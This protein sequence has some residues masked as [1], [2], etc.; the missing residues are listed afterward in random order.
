MWRWLL[1]NNQIYTIGSTVI[2][3]VKLTE[4]GYR[5]CSRIDNH[6]AAPRAKNM[7]KQNE[8][9]RGGVRKT[10]RISAGVI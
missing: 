5:S 4:I 8:G 9:E 6:P 10:G 7:T 1:V 3:F 2:L